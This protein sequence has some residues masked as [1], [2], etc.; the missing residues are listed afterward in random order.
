MVDALTRVME[1]TTTAEQRLVLARQA[2]MIVRSAEESVAEPNDL[3][4]IHSRY[5]NFLAKAA[6]YDPIGRSPAP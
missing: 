2:E 5:R 6:L 3:E 4:D 1:E